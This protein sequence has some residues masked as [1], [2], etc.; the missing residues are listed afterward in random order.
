MHGDIEKRKS[1]FKRAACSNGDRITATYDKSVDLPNGVVDA[2]TDNEN[3]QYLFN[4]GKLAG[5]LNDSAVS[6]GECDAQDHA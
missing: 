4:E 1:V 2:Y 6:S 3:N 5:F